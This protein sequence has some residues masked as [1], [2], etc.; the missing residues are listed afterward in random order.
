MREKLAIKQRDSGERL[1]CRVEKA[2]HKH[3]AL[4][5]NKRGAPQVRKCRGARGKRR[6]QKMEKWTVITGDIFP[7]IYVGYMLVLYIT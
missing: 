3:G 5:K 2:A 4:K 7:R 6:S 1:R